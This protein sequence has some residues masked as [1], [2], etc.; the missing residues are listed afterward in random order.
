MYMADYHL[1]TNFSSDSVMSMEEAIIKAI[2]LGLKEIALTDHVDYDYPDDSINY[3]NYDEYL[4]AFN[5]LKEKYEDKI[6]LILGVEIGLQPHVNED[7]IEFLKKYPFDFVIA[8]T[9][10]INGME[11]YSQ[12]YFKQKTKKEAYMIYF[13]EILWEVQN[14]KQYNVYGHFD[15]VM[16][17]GYYEDSS[18][19]Y[20]E[21]REIIDEILKKIITNGSGLEINT[22]GFRYKRKEIYP[23]IDILKKYREL[24][25]EIISVGSAA[26]T[27]DYITCSFDY[28]YE[29]LKEVGFLYITLFEKGK[30]KHL[31]I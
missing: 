12:E 30:P 6:K 18:L 20:G 24:G 14:F 4:L 5:K 19:C 16:R 1:H 22:S 28:V 25:G 29:I 21:Y 2:K 10:V 13:E 15:Y 9:H 8:S 23:Q 17:Y 27:T 26:H 3:I 31:K 7:N 11:L